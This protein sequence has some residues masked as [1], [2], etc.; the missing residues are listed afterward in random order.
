M[1]D[2]HDASVA[3]L[4]RR[5]AALQADIRAR[6]DFIAIAAHELRNPMQ[7]ILSSAEL[8]LV[9]ARKAGNA[10]PARVTH[11]LEGMHQL[12][13][14]YVARATRLLDVTRI[15]AGNLSLD[16]VPTDLSALAAR[17][18]A[19]FRPIASRSGSVLTASIDPEVTGLWDPLALEQIIENLLVNAIKFGAGR[20]IAITLHNERRSARLNIRDHGIGMTDE[21]VEGIF[22]RF[23][24]AVKEHRGSGFGIG[25]WVAGRLVHALGGE[26]TVTSRP[27][28]G[29]CFVVQLPT[30]APAA[31]RSNA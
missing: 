14:D 9:A 28:D 2:E 23:A 1:P 5:I 24:Q 11:L 4:H 16:F 18:V 27:G 8:A 6:D 12:V 15:A 13:E 22:G 20:P 3:S 17:I 10:C 25:L 29:S 26:I 31:D 30:D 21:Q 19:R 7:P